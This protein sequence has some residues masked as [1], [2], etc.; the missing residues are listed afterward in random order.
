MLVQ[1]A[2]KRNRCLDYRCF[3]GINNYRQLY[4]TYM[5]LQDPYEPTPYKWNATRVLV[6]LLRWFDKA[7]SMTNMHWVQVDI[8]SSAPIFFGVYFFLEIPPFGS[9]QHPAPWQIEV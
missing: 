8:L 4:E 2:M 9:T 1:G 5:T 3:L 7:N 6:S